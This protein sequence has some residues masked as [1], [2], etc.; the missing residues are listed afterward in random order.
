MYIALPMLASYERGF[1]LL[2]L[3]LESF[4]PWRLLLQST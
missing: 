1:L 4:K 2:S 3:L